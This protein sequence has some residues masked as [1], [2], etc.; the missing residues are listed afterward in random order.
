M[1]KVVLLGHEATMEI[2]GQ[3]GDPELPWLKDD[4]IVVWLRFNE[5]VGYILSFAI[6]LPARE[7][8]ADEFLNLVKRE[9]ERALKESLDKHTQ[10]RINRQTREA[11]QKELDE[12]ASQIAK[13]LV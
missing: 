3:A 9:G 1:N 6:E 12:L 11:R 7:Y 8:K 13:S 4:K 2:S 5:A 10:A